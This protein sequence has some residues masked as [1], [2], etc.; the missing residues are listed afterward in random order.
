MDRLTDK[1][2]EVMATLIAV[3]TA[4]GVDRDT[5]RA[6]AAN[7]ATAQVAVDGVA[8][9]LAASHRRA[10]ATDGPHGQAADEAARSPEDAPQ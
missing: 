8:E 2:H 4:A 1:V 9:D 5:V 6:V 10:D 7:L 3:Q